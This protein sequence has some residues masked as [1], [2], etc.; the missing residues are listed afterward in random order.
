MVSTIVLFVILSAFSGLR[1]FS[2]KMLESS[3]PDIKLSASKGKYLDFTA[4]L[5][6]TLSK[7]K[8]I[9]HISPIIEERVFLQY[10]DKKAVAQ[11]KGVDVDYNKVINID[12]VM[13]VGTWLDREFPKAVV[14]GEG[15]AYKL[16]LRV[17]DLGTPLQ[18][19]TPKAGKG[20]IN[21]NNAF[22]SVNTTIFG[23]FG[24]SE[25]FRNTYIFSEIS[26]ARQ[27]L[28]LKSEQYTA[29]ELKLIDNSNSMA[30]KKDLQQILGDA[31]KVET[32]EELN[33]LY[34]KVV[35]TENFIGYLIGTLITIIALFN[36]LGSIIM[37]IIDKKANLNTLFKIGASIDEIKKIFVFQGVLLTLTGLVIGLI[38]SISLILLQIE[39]EFFM[40]TPTIPY[41]VEFQWSNLIIVITTIMVLGF[42]A[43]QIASSRITKAFIIE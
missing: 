5:Q 20:F 42:G 43:S 24:G 16:S 7:T 35:N 2:T 1:T 10:G 26:I 32:R 3:D 39:Y 31:F 15:I 27:L 6:Q 37:M 21:P 38:I 9:K 41:P 14:I 18:I 29:I 17:L 13:T 19:M 8:V 33:S 25:A 22:N 30:V 23:A 36:I 4:D 28:E 34:Y 12:T 11:L 40:I